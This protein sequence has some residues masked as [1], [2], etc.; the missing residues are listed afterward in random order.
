[1]LS[2]AYRGNAGEAEDYYEH[3]NENEEYYDV[4]SESGEWQGSGLSGLGI[5]EGETVSKEQFSQLLRGRSPDGQDLV[6][7]AGESHRAGW[8]LT[9]S[10][11]KS[12]SVVWGLSDKT[13]ADAIM[14]A[15]NNAVAKALE[16]IEEQAGISRS[17]VNG[18]IKQKAGLIVAKYTHE[19]SRNN[20]MQL[21]THSFVMNVSQR[22]DGKYGAIESRKIFQHKMS[23]GAV[24]RAELAHQ[25]RELG[26]QTEQDGDSFR[27]TNLDK[28]LETEFSTRRAEILQ[29]LKES[30]HTGAKASEIAALSTRSAKDHSTSK[31]EIKQN[32]LD[33]A[34]EL[35]YTTE[36]IDFLRENEAI[37]ERAINK[38]EILE[39]LTDKTSVF[40]RRDLTR[41]IS[42]YL[43]DKGGGY[44]RVKQIQ[45][46]FE[47]ENEIIHLADT[48][49]GEAILTTRTMLNLERDMLN[50]A[51][52]LSQ[53]STHTVSEDLIDKAIDEFHHDKDWT[54]D[55][56]QINALKHITLGQDISLVTGSAGGGKS[57]SLT[58]A[59]NV[60]KQTG[61]NVIGSCIS[62][63]AASGLSA[64]TNNLIP[65]QT[66]AS[67]L[68]EIK[69][70]HKALTNKDILV[71]DESGMIDSRTMQKLISLVG[72]ADA[73]LV[74]VGD[75]TK[76]IQSIQAGGAHR[77]LQV[78]I[79]F[80]EVVEHRRQNENWAKNASRDIRDGN[81]VKALS[82][83]HQRGF[84]SFS[85][86]RTEAISK[87]VN[88]YINNAKN[89]L[90][91]TLML[92][93][94]RN[95]VSQLNAIARTKLQEIGIIEKEEVTIQTEMGKLH[96]SLGDRLLFTKNNKIL[97]VKNGNLGILKDI[98]HFEDQV[99]MTI[100]L[101]GGIT[102]Q[103]SSDEYNH[104]QHGYAITTHKSQGATVQHTHV[105]TGSSMTDLQSTYV[106]L[107]RHKQSAHIYSDRRAI[108][109]LA[110]MAELPN[111]KM[112]DY[113][114]DIAEKENLELPEHWQ[115]DFIVCRDFLNEHAERF[116]Y[117]ENEDK[118]LADLKLL[119]EAM[120]KD[121]VKETTLDYI[122]HHY[123]KEE[124]EL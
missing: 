97:N 33:R 107:T 49:T 64:S 1:M 86:D 113:A 119:A 88:G 40:K 14:Q 123:Q 50:K 103:I 41:K 45:E 100:E 36:M 105:L 34:E 37:K 4:Q 66:I 80:A 83:Y 9:F 95:E 114:K 70:G 29:A 124:I 32:W 22:E 101:D 75:P 54:L 120:S 59:A 19:T 44:D 117:A 39:A 17:G 115:T 96:L 92:A 77:A 121:N 63:K 28:K 23:A 31:L 35:G 87:T 69:N 74:L 93:S 79:G 47:Q 12:I 90:S 72:Q 25:I 6:K 118:D 57:V 73:K 24:Y 67:L 84:L 46:E 51:I 89:S 7:N 60:W 62:G 98:E 21:H 104:L 85:D 81:L 42:L 71:I 68:I 65:S 111:P 15:H 61:F 10:A 48:R 16:Y 91:E 102:V 109:Q 53:K 108:E 26:Y 11:P 94:T 122:Q 112:V 56:E 52:K 20:D 116:I 3:L 43:Q 106:N 82:E 18:E 110:A 55:E 99:M 38:E 2:I 76:Q 8:D 13:N 30:G 78:K 5:E 58:V 27:I